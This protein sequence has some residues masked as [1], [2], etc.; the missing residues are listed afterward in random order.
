VA[1]DRGMQTSP[2][3]TQNQP[4]YVLMVCTE[5]CIKTVSDQSVQALPPQIVFEGCTQ[6]RPK[7]TKEKSTPISQGPTCD[8]R[9]EMPLLNTVDNSTQMNR[10]VLKDR[11]TGM[12]PVLK[13][14]PLAPLDQNCPGPTLTPNSTKSCRPTPKSTQRIS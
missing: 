5:D 4:T 2:I 3:P 12:P 10:A 8:R 6:T 9:T 11:G 14:Y 1:C 13:L 7:W